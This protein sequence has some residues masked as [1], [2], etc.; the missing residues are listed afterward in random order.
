MGERLDRW[1]L[2]KHSA[3]PFDTFDRLRAGLA[4]VFARPRMIGDSGFGRYGDMG[5]S[6]LNSEFTILD[7]RYTIGRKTEI[8]RRRS[9]N[10]GTGAVFLA[11]LRWIRLDR[12]ELRCV[13]FEMV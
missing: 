4:P 8:I 9:G 2:K 6:P 5:A 1:T 10:V 7:L 3:R 13:Q 12:D 11:G